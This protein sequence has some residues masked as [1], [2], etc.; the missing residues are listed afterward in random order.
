MKRAVGILFVLLLWASPSFAQTA[1]CTTTLADLAVVT[2]D[3]AITN[4]AEIRTGH[5]AELW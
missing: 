2:F 1:E 3:T 5:T 4:A